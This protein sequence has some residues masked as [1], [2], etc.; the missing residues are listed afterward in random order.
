M[1]VAL[2][3]FVLPFFWLLP[4]EL[5][6]G[7]DSNRLFLYDPESYL[8]VNA[9]FSVEPQGVGKV[10]PNQNLLPFLILLQLLNTIFHS[11]YLLMTLLN[12][13]KLVGSF[14]FMYLI[15]G[16]LLSH[17][18]KKGETFLVHLTGI[19]SGIFYT[20]SP[21]VGANMRSALLTHNQVFLNPMIFYFMLRLFVT[22][23]SKYLWLALLTTLVFSPNFSL[24]APPPPFSFYPLALLFLIVYV[25]FC[26]KKSLPWKK[27]LLGFIF[28]L[29]IHAFQIVPAVA[30]IIDPSSDYYTRAFDVISGRNKALEYFNATLGLGKVSQHIFF[31]YSDKMRWTAFAVPL[32]VIIGFLLNKKRQKALML[33]AI[34]FFITLFLTSANITQIGV[35]IYRKLFYIPGFSMFRVFYGQWQWVHAF[36]YAL[37]FGFSLYILLLRLKRKYVYS[38]SIFFAVLFII[39]GWT[40]ING[41]VLRTVHQGSKNMT[42]IIRMNPDYEKT[43]A[44]I[45]ALPDDGKI[46]NLP[47]NDFFYQIIPGTNNAAY[48][49]LSPTSYLTGKRTFSGY[50]IMYP[51]PEV[52]LKLAK[53]KNYAAIKRLF[54]LLNINY[55]FYIKDP[56]A[57][58]EYYPT[59]PYSLFLQSVPDSQ[60]LAEMVDGIRGEKIFQQGFYSIYSA[61]KAHYLPHF[62]VPA[63]IKPYDNNGDWYGKNVSFF[64]E[65][66]D[67]DP[68]V[69][70]IDREQCKKL[71]SVDRCANTINLGNNMPTISFKR[72]NPIKYSVEVSGA[73][74]PF[75]LIF[76]DQF[77]KDWKLYISKQRPQKLTV[78]QSY[79][80]GSVK[81]YKHENIFLDSRTFETLGMK[82]ISESQH[83]IVNG[84]ANAWLINPDDTSGASDYEIIIEMT[85]QRLFYYSLGISA[86]SLLIFLFYGITLLKK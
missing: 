39:S 71:F 13:V 18:F 22:H 68:R 48:I 19:L 75:T 69:G 74:G 43:L 53:E 46:F 32:V 26:L 40:F 17:Q 56:K 78:Q 70:Y 27:L 54:G 38:L 37:L 10:A 42:S 30:H 77:H 29:G 80:N 82:S 36:F 51:F 20:L 9:L 86:V 5:E 57:F 44:F 55:I 25:P 3:L 6:M 21:S 83:F 7:G 4:G 28:F 2:I 79:F 50:Q 84:Y 23:Q 67:S 47:F 59:W 16:E 65:G 60:A 52:F 63:S 61:D 66:S 85:Q 76:S 31:T 11:Q 58:T 24:I 12:S 34:F 35:E 73:A 45:K 15:V 1:S 49:G 81:E 14:L 64:V 41:Q 72:I 33:I 62:Y 8:Q